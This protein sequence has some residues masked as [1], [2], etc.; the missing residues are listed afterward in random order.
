MERYRT[1][2]KAH[3][4]HTKSRKGRIPHKT[5]SVHTM[6]NSSEIETPTDLE[7][8]VKHETNFSGKYYKYCNRCEE[9]CCWCFTSNWEEGLN[10][11]NLDSSVDI[12]PSPTAKKPPAGWSESRCRV[13]RKTDTTGPPSPREEISTD[14]GTSM[15]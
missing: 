11:N 12:L 6:E 2:D 13:I 10:A 9:T 7:G 8:E 14:S 3:K 5:T 15:H 1:W 4:D